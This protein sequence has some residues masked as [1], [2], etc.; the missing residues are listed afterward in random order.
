MNLAE[1][2]IATAAG[3]LPHPPDPAPADLRRLRR[4]VPTGA[5]ARMVVGSVPASV[6]VR[7]HTVP[8]AGAD[9]AARVYRVRADAEAERAAPRAR[10]LVVC[11][12]GGGFVIGDPMQ[13]EWV[14]GRLAAD[15][16]AVVVSVAYRRAPEH[17]APIPADDCIAA[18]RWLTAHAGLFGADAHRVSVIGVSAGATLAALVAQAL[19]DDEVPVHRQVLVYPATDLTLSSPSV[20]E[21]AAGPILTRPLLDWF[22]ERYLPRGTDGLPSIPGDDPR[23]SPLHADLT[24]LPPA[25]IMVAGRD[26]LRDDGIR[27]AHAL[28]TAGTAAQLIIFADAMHGFISMPGISPAAHRAADA[29]IG[30]LGPDLDR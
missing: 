3:W 21:F 30:F 8:G 12:H 6:R 23:V 7:P 26:A 10:S 29:M 13:T 15:L 11:F 28:Q 16:D 18:A 5:V 25:L 27:Y 19:R 24:G 2:G 9:L 4:G 22:G 14:C 20:A 1:R 17:P